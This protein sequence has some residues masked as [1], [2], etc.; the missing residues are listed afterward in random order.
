MSDES[1]SFLLGLVMGVAILFF[2]FWALDETQQPDAGY[3]NHYSCKGKTE[4]INSHY[5][6]V[7]VV[8]KTCKVVKN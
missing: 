2:G 7:R 1:I 3:G 4:V 5:Y 6:G 8:G